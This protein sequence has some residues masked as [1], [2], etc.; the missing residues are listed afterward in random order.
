MG[1]HE[2][3]GEPHFGSLKF[4]YAISGLR[5]KPTSGQESWAWAA[6]LGGVI[7]RLC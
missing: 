7:L 1:G 4:V 5:D 2:S 6:P 3:P